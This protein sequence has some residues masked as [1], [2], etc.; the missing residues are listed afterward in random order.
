VAVGQ[1]IAVANQKG[2]VGKTTTTVNLAAALAEREQRVLVVDLDPQH[3]ATK[4]FG[5]HAAGRTLYHVLAEGA[6]LAEIVVPVEG[7]H[8]APADLDLDNAQAKLWTVPGRDMLLRGS[9]EGAVDRYDVVL[10]DCPP[11]LNLFTANALLAA[12][13]V[14]VPVECELPAIAALPDLFG[15]VELVQRHVNRTLHVLGVLVNRFNK[16][17][18]LHRESLTYLRH[19][20]T[21]RYRLLDTMIPAGIRIPEAAQARQSVVRYDPNSPATAA[22]RALASEVIAEIQ[23]AL[24]LPERKG[25]KSGVLRGTVAHG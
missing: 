20:L 8:V 1:V 4:L 2:G 19:Q 11:N 3:T 22:Y 16:R 13:E 5:V 6:P 9:L 14:L 24:T 15:T 21:G 10:L 18:V 25:T 12:D 23:A 7:F 17:T